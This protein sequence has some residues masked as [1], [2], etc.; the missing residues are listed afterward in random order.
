M[1]QTKKE[2]ILAEAKAKFPKAWFKD[3]A[4]FNG[5]SAVLWSGEG[6]E[7]N[8]GCPAFDSTGCQEYLMIDV[9]EEFGVEYKPSNTYEFGVHKDLVEFADEHGLFW[10]A[11]DGG[12]Y[13]AYEV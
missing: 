5:G 11:Y 12:T 3:G 6:S 2:K 9:C 7:V 1:N 10:E 4:E 13:F 8:N